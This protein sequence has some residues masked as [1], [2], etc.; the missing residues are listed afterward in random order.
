MG[1]ALILIGVGCM[2][3]AIAG[4]GVKL[5]QLELGAV[6]SLWRQGLLGVFGLMISAF[7]FAVDQDYFKLPPVKGATPAGEPTNSSGAVT[8]ARSAANT[9]PAK[10]SAVPALANT[11]GPAGTDPMQTA[12]ENAPKPKP[13][14]TK[15]EVQEQAAL[16]MHDQNGLPIVD[17]T[18]LWVDESGHKLNFAQEGAKVTINGGDLPGSSAT[19]TGAG[20]LYRESRIQLDLTKGS[21]ATEF[22][23]GPTDPLS[24]TLMGQNPITGTNVRHTTLKRIG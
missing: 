18:G 11:V 23:R 13:P 2:I 7:G 12:A 19:W 10:T 6:P 4:G 17:V 8:G 22:C 9:A 1:S 14:T 20:N 16:T 5:Q 3:A 15:T 21:S 24:M